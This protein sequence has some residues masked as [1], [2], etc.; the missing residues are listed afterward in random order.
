M[1][2]ETVVGSSLSVI[3]KQFARSLLE[4]FCAHMQVYA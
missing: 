3:F 2:Q 1:H 4:I